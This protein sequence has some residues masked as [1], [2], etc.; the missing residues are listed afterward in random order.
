MAE[1]APLRGILYNSQAIGN[2]ADVVAPPYDII[3]RDDVQ[4]YYERH[5]KNIIRLILGKVDSNGTDERLYNRAAEYFE[6]W[7][8]EGTFSQDPDPTIYIYS[9][10]Y[11][12]PDGASKER[13]GFIARLKLEDFDSGVVRPHEYTFKG[14]RENRLNLIRACRANFDQIF[15]VYPDPAM[16][17]D[18]VMEEIARA[19]KEIYCVVDEEKV[20]NRLWRI[21]DPAVVKF[22]VEQMA[23]KEVLVADGHHRYEAALAFRDEMRAKG[24]NGDGAGYVMAYL[25]NMHAPGL[26]ILPYHRVIKG[27][28]ELNR[29]KLHQT[30]SGKFVLQEI[31]P[32][33][34]EER[35]KTLKRLLEMELLDNAKEGKVFG[36][37]GRECGFWILESIEDKRG[38]EDLPI[39][40]HLLS[41]LD[42]S[43]LHRHVII[44]LLGT[45]SLKTGEEGGV[46]YISDPYEALDMVE[47]QESDAAFFMNPIALEDIMAIAQTGGRMPQKSTF[48]YPKPITGMVINKLDD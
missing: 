46:R 8:R 14:P 43:I 3:S 7:V 33:P 12:L 4:R 1:I 38:Q 31:K 42:V 13:Y 29:L 35:C 21:V 17:I 18:N 47:R 16:S 2:L 25:V 26:S 10:R 9:Q 19:E 6:S 34:G 22:V 15:C 24:G 40:E 20:T 36:M 45:D 32:H 27:L 44:P 48:F 28:E 23:D 39:V 11:S 41:E 37:Y 30:L 5:E